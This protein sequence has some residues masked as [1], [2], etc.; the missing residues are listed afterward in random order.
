MCSSV[1]RVL[2]GVITSLSNEKASS[3]GTHE[4]VIIKNIL[5]T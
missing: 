5:E 4:L 3:E 2:S 1:N